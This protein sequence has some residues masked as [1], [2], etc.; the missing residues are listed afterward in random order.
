MPTLGWPISLA[1]AAASAAV[2]RKKVSKRLMGSMAKVTPW[3]S[4]CVA[5][6]LKALDSPLPFLAGAPAAGEVAYRAN[7]GSGDDGSAGLG[8]GFG[9]HFEVR[10][11][12]AADI[13]IVADEAE[14]VDQNGTHGAFQA[15]RLES[16]ANGGGGKLPRG[17]A[18]AVR[19]HQSRLAL[20]AAAGGSLTRQ[21]MP[22]TGMC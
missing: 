1:R 2:L 15:I 5:Q 20:C 8:G 17:A 7:E 16:P 12:A 19:R 14:A 22:T 3:A 9:D 21:R 13:G 6:R 11:G 10:A 4:Q 18:E